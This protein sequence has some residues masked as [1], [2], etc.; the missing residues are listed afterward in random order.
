MA[1]IEFSDAE[2]GA[3]GFGGDYLGPIERVEGVN[4][5]EWTPADFEKNIREV[6]DIYRYGMDQDSYNDKL[7]RARQIDDLAPKFSDIE[8]MKE[9]FGGQ[10]TEG[11]IR[12]YRD[13]R[14]LEDARKVYGSQITDKE[15]QQYKNK[16]LQEEAKR[17]Y[18]VPMTD[19]EWEKFKS[20]YGK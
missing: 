2:L 4:I 15:F 18:G 7:W 11:E 13:R 10:M 14:M 19:K 1:R 9:Y 12:R 16:M 5:D 20:M 6:R 17:F 8:G 3:E